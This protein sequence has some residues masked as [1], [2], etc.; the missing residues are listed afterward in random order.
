M[1]SGVFHT[2]LL[3]AYLAVQPKSALVGRNNLKE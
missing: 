3:S 1:Q 2:T